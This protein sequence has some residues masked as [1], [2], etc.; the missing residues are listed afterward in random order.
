MIHLQMLFQVKVYSYLDR[1]NATGWTQQ[2]PSTWP[3]SEP[4]QISS[5]LL[6]ES[7][8]KETKLENRE[9]EL[10]FHF[11]RNR[12]TLYSVTFFTSTY[13]FNSEIG[14]DDFKNH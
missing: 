1:S 9:K 2:T 6:V 11:S 5:R 8:M 13:R 7:L 3:L 12:A 4:S 10:R 14:E